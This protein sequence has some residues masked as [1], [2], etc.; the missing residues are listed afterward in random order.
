M[1]G[2][3]VLF[4]SVALSLS[5]CG[6]GGAGGGS[7]SS[8]VGSSGCNLTIHELQAI[9]NI[10]DIPQECLSMLPAPEDN[11]LGRMFILGTQVDQASGALRIFVNG[12]DNDGN[13]LQLTDFQSA[14]VSIDGNP[15]D[16]NRVSVDPIAA[17]DDVLSLGF[18]TDYSTSISDAE[19]AKVSDIYSI[20]LDSL[21]PP[22]LPPVMEG[23]VIDF[24]NSVLVKQD[25]TE[26]PA[27]LQAAYQLDAGFSRQNTALYDALG[28]ALKR[29]PAVIDDGLVERCRPAH[30]LITFT[31]GADNASFTYTKET[32]LPIIQDSEAVMIMLGSLSADKTTLMNLAGDQG[33]FVYAYN[34]SGIQST[35]QKWADSLSQM[36]KFTLDPATG[37]DAGSITITLGGETV[38]VER[39]VDGFCES[40]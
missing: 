38:A 36:V 12:T 22:N 1:P 39:P 4:L 30:M 2:W 32:L 24:S 23:M 20:I 21:S 16:P 9:G 26:D 17:G 8:N 7:S 11:L 18:V 27:L 14:T 31:D 3:A 13:P 19:L 28:V 35:V 10:N 37:F 33:A 5:G 15:V 40:P 34:L 29:D 6:G 25:W